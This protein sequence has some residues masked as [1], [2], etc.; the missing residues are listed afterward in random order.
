[1]LIVDDLLTAPLKGIYWIFQEIH[2]AALQE[3]AGEAE[4]ITA[5]LSELY[6]LLDTGQITEAEFD[7]QEKALLDRLDQI[8]Q[9][10]TRLAA[11]KKPKTVRAKKLGGK[12]PSA[13]RGHSK[14]GKVH[15]GALAPS[16]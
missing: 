9:P 10:T 13:S 8:Q 3:Q 15:E 12:R 16:P 6:M 14:R 1:M 11:E 7:S 5:R 4:M 2:N